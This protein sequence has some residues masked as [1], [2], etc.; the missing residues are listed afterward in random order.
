[1]GIYLLVLTGIVHYKRLFLKKHYWEINAD[2]DSKVFWKAAALEKCGNF[3]S[4]F[5]QVAGFLLASLL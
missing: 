5:D 1:M 3:K 2:N 4:Y